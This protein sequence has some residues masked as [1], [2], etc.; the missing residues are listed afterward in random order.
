[1]PSNLQALRQRVCND[2]MLADSQNSTDCC[3]TV[4]AQHDDAPAQE[5]VN[6]NPMTSIAPVTYSVLHLEVEWAER[7]I[8]SVHQHM[9]V[10][11]L[12]ILPP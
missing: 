5:S 7:P 6:T 2:T 10:H 8:S 1:M 12:F 4:S 9:T 3:I 11:R